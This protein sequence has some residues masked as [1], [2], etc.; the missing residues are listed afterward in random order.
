[1]LSALILVVMVTAGLLQHQGGGIRMRFR[2]TTGA[3]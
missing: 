1:V 3:A 2:A